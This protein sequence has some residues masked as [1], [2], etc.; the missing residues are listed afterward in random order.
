MATVPQIV[1]Y[2]LMFISVLGGIWLFG[3][4]RNSPANVVT[5]C[6]A[7]AVLG[8]ACSYLPYLKEIHST[9]FTILMAEQAPQLLALEKRAADLKE[10]VSRKEHEVAGKQQQLDAMP[11]ALTSSQ[12]KT[13]L[14]KKNSPAAHKKWSC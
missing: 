2:T 9:L 4:R 5:F 11:D 14:I 7:L 1:G 8:F 12:K 6:I 10:E 13:S 3:F